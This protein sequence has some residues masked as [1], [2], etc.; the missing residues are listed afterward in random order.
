MRRGSTPKERHRAGVIARMGGACYA[1]AHGSCAGRIQAA[2]WIDAQTLRGIQ[3]NTRMAIRANRQV[4]EGRLL[5]VD[6]PLDGLIA[7]DR[8]GAPL[9][10]HHHASFDKRNGQK[11]ILHPPAEVVEFAAEYGLE[12]WLAWPDRVA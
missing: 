4:S 9:C 10:E 11:L 1:R 5:L 12:D 7:D 8:N 3:A 2:H 6:M